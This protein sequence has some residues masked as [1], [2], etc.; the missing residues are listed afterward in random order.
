[1]LYVLAIAVAIVMLTPV[2][3]MISGSL[4]TGGEVVSAQ[5]TLLPSDPQWRNY[6]DL[7]SLVPF[8][9]YILNSF[10]VSATVTIVALLFHSMAGYSL[11]RLRY[12]GRRLIFLAILATMMVP[13]A[14]ILIPLFTIVRTFGWIDSYQALIIPAIPHAFGIFLF[15]Q[16]YLSVP[17]DLSD[18]AVVDGAGYVRIYRHVMLPLSRPIVAALGIF[19]FL[20]N[21]NSFLWPLVAT[22]SDEMRVIQLGIQ[23]FLGAHAN[24]YQLVMTAATVAAAPTL[25]MFIV[26]QRRLVQ[27]IKTTGLKG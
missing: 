1:V 4:K 5:P 18:A 21:W 6:G 15:R 3:W 25:L 13:A 10:V 19:F 12:P 14:V 7:F 22:Q 26:L 9:R 8:A 20:A 2:V 17:Q 27:G 23:A 11:A 24:Q 16:F